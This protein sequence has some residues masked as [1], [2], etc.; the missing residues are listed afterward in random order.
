MID[1]PLFYLAAIPA[2]VLTGLSKGGLGA[3]FGLAAVPILA[4]VVSPIRAAGL[5]HK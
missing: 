3:A 4:L 1:D 2:V 5:M